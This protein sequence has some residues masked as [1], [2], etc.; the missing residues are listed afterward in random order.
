MAIGLYFLLTIAVELPI[1]VLWLR[2]EWKNALWIGLL[3][4]LFTW[5][6]LVTLISITNWNIP[7]MEI[8]VVL[9]EGWGYQ[10]FFRRGWIISMSMSLLVNGISYGLGLL[11]DYAL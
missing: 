7:V 9:I 6:S 11:I 2:K 8:G 3:L 5:P 1:V 4:N 10:L